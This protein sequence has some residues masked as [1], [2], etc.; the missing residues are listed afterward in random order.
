MTD[1]KPRDSWRQVISRAAWWG[2][3]TALFVGDIIMRLT[4]RNTQLLIMHGLNYVIIGLMV[5]GVI[6]GL[7]LFKPWRRR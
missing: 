6:G 3:V 7:A 5:V 1:K 2:L 4:S